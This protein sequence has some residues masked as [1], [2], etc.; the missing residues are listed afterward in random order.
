MTYKLTAIHALPFPVFHLTAD[1]SPLKNFV[2][3][4]HD[5]AVLNH[6]LFLTLFWH[7]ST[8]QMLVVD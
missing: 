5:E 2:D 1:Q 4:D 6:T 7:H 3:G 8:V